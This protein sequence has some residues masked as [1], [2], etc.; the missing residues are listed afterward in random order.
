[1][2]DLVKEGI[3]LN[4]SL[5]LLPL[6]AARRLV[7]DRNTMAKQMVELAEDLVSTPFV[8]AA[9]AVDSISR[10]SVR[11]GNFVRAGSCKSGPTWRNIWVNPEV[12]VFSDTEVRPGQRR[13]V[14]TVKGL[15]CGS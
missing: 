6:K 9:R 11:D 12:T 5:A 15:L 13:A 7:D 2:L 8:A 4:Q 1:M 3:K 10:P 14:L